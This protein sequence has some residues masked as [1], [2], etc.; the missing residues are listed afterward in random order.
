V[1]LYSALVE[2]PSAS[3]AIIFVF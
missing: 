1:H 2:R 3:I